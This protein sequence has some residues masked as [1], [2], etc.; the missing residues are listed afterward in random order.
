MEVI[1]PYS[2]EETKNRNHCQFV[3]VN[4][5]V[6]SQVCYYRMQGLGANEVW[7]EVGRTVE[8]YLSQSKTLDQ[9]LDDLAAAF[10]KIMEDRPIR[11]LPI[12]CQ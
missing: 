8:A 3:A 12:T 9:S 7:Q 2:A 5:V 6:V 10:D 1:I 4:E 11:E